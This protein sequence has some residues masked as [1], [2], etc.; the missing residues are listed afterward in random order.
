MPPPLSFEAFVD[1]LTDTYRTVIHRNLPVPESERERWVRP[2][3]LA[4]LG[5]GHEQE[6]FYFGYAL[7]LAEGE[8]P[9]GASGALPLRELLDPG[10]HETLVAAVDRFSYPPP[11]ASEARDPWYEDCQVFAR[12]ALRLGLGL[13]AHRLGS[14]PEMLPMAPGPG[15]RV[16]VFDDIESPAFEAEVPRC[17]LPSSGDGDQAARR[18]LLAGAFASTPA[19]RELLAE[20]GEGRLLHLPL[21]EVLEMH[22]TSRVSLLA[23]LQ[24]AKGPSR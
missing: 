1:T 7:G 14:H 24:A 13:V 4:W 16:T 12:Y 19:C 11:P 20:L 2:D 17:E 5:L 10:E 23:D 15:F 8:E 9:G 21:T 18:Q 3:E 22:R 6:S